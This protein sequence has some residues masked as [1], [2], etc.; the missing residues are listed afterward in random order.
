MVSCS[1]QAVGR[2]RLTPAVGVNG[3]PA[4]ALR[5]AARLTGAMIHRVA[6]AIWH[7]ASTPQQCRDSVVTPLFKKGDRHDPGHYRR[8]AIKDTDSKAYRMWLLSRIQP[9]VERVHSDTF[10]AYR[11]AQGTADPLF[12][13]RRV[14]EMAE[15]S[16]RRLWFVFCGL[17]EGIRH[18]GP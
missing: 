18:C 13:V 17:C 5:Q 11:I 8:I 6:L 15:K 16:R 10:Y 2:L 1:L 7:V 12:A 4:V 3:I 14:V 9:V